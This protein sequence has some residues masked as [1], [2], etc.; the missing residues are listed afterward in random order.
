MVSSDYSPPTRK[1]PESGRRAVPFLASH[2]SVG[3]RTAG[4]AKPARTR[5]RG[6]SARQAA[7]AGGPPERGLPP[8]LPLRQWGEAGGRRA[9]ATPLSPHLRPTE[10]SSAAAVRSRPNPP[11]PFR[12]GSC[13]GMVLKGGAYEL[14]GDCVTGHRR[15]GIADEFGLRAG[16]G[17]PAPRPLRGRR[18]LSQDPGWAGSEPGSPTALCL[19]HLRRRHA[20]HRRG[21]SVHGQSGRLSEPGTGR[22]APGRWRWGR[23]GRSTLAP[24]PRRTYSG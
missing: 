3:L 2:R 17:V 1:R 5:R 10:M 11:G 24:C 9:S 23:T 14:P 15:D 4:A 6:A 13:Y 8:P 22:S 21:G 16:G 18:R 20:G 12:T 19:A 7:G